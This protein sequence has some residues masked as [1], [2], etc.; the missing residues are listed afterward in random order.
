L[1]ITAARWPRL[2]NAVPNSITGYTSPALPIVGSSISS[3][4]EVTGYVL[5]SA[6][7][8]FGKKNICF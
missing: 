7:A 6:V 1:V 3:A 2:F 4:P 5:A 8:P